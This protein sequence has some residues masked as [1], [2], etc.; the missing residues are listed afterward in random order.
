MFSEFLVNKF[1]KDNTNIKNDAVRNS[2]GILG[3][4]IGIC[5]NAIL[6]LIKLSVGFFASSIA[7]I[8]DAFNN[9]SDA[10]S[11]LI[12]ILGFKLA[13]K[14]ADKE[15]PFGHGRIEYL[16][17][18]IVAFM[19]MLVGLQFIKSSITR[20]TNPETVKFELIPFILLLISIGLKVWLSIFNKF[21]GNKINSSALKAASVDALGDVFTSS[22][23]A[24]SFFLSK[25][26][27]LPIDGFIGLGVA[28]FIVYSGFS[29]VKD[30]LNPLLGE[31]PD[32]ELVKAI[33]NM[34]LSYENITGVHDL[35]IHNYGPGKCMASI[36]AEI[37]ASIDIMKI[38]EI[39]DKAE[40]EISESLKIYLVIHMDPIC[41]IEGEVKKAYDEI[42]KLIN[43]Y[44]HIESI[45]DFRVI[46]EGDIKNLIFDVVLNNSIKINL[47]DDEIKENISSRI[48]S[49]HPNYNCII[50][51]DKHFL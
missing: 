33:Q 12:T 18:L 6:F 50:T 26:T 43:E 22:T 41:I 21:M 17:A 7:I 36:H 35:I 1:I 24:V 19:V 28:V 29:L 40:R 27:S 34:V 45:H 39:I 25:F 44:D 20:I 5:V 8:A 10:A 4:I 2:Y 3:G 11:S 42:L 38:H 16:S 15:H 31:A 23:V 9:L 49:I 13:S 51:L 30:T 47:T 48:K 14:P 46:G 32:P 37:P